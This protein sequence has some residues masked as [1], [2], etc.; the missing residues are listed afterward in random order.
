MASDYSLAQSDG[1][2]SPTSADPY[3][4]MSIGIAVTKQP[5]QQRS[6][7]SPRPFD[8][9]FVPPSPTAQYDNGWTHHR[10]GGDHG[11]SGG[12]RGMGS[13]NHT[14]SNDSDP[15]QS[16]SN[17]PKIFS[18][19]AG[20]GH[21]FGHSSGSIETLQKQM[22]VKDKV[23][24]DLAVIVEALEIN[25]GFSI[26]DHTQIFQNFS[27]IALSMEKGARAAGSPASSILT[28]GSYRRL[29][30][31]IQKANLILGQASDVATPSSSTSPY[32]HPPTDYERIITAMESFWNLVNMQ[33]LALA[34]SSGRKQAVGREL[35]SIGAL[36]LLPRGWIER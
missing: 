8:G 20:S 2:M 15:Q 14:G 22:Q 24:A 16:S 1:V 21:H 18:A 4:S 12:H 5:S 7:R 26:Y 3:P 11:I 23:I 13:H 30:T 27:H 36:G 10:V 32:G 6:S 25:F 35:E 17:S 33:K 28:K 29:C 34:K 19:S 31:S 9:D